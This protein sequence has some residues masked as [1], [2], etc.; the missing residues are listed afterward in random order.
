ML[1]GIIKET[2]EGERRIAAV[3]ETISKMVKSGMEVLVET[4]AGNESFIS[5]ADFEVAGAKIAPDAASVLSQSDLIL[6]VNKPTVEEVNNI[7]EG[8][9]L[10]SF[11]QPFSS[12]EVI[13]ALAAR[14]VAALSMEMVPR[15]TRAQRIDALSTMSTVAGYKVVLLAA[16]ACGRFMPMLAT[17]AGTIPPA[18]AMIIGVGV[19]GLQAIA[20]IKRLGAVVTA[21]DVRPAAGEQAKSLG[22]EFVSLEVPHDQ[23]ED[24]GGYARE[25]SADFYKKEQ[26]ILR[27]HIKD[28]DV[29]IT[30]ALIPGKRA[31]LLITEEMVKEMKPGSVIVDMAVEQGGNC[32]LSEAGK[33]VLRHGVA[34]IGQV[35]IPSTMPVH[36]SLLYARNLLAFVNLV[37]PDG[38]SMN[39]DLSDDVIIGSLITHNGEIVHPAIKDAVK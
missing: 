8:A 19:A 6:K 33:D 3:P 7:K 21:F 16:S 38:K 31:P 32:E 18:K 12:P 34:I 30:T 10:I 4:G 27:N 1:V 36:A 28:A 15:I 9:V 11:L 25:M 5:D 39:I 20:T 17:A 22:A 24:T 37:S 2:L 13:K 23:A 35:N 29:V 14:K 26:D